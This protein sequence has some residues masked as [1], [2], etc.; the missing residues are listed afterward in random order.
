[1][2]LNKGNALSA[3]ERNQLA[4]QVHKYT[5]LST[6]YLLAANFRVSEN[7][8]VHELLK[9]R[10][11]TL[12]RLD[13]RFPGPTPDPLAKYTSYDPQSSSIGPA[14]V[15]AFQDYYHGEL[16]FGEGK[17]YRT[18]NYDIGG[19][20]KWT[21]R[22]AGNGDEQ[23]IVNS[24][25][26]LAQALVEDP[27]LKVLVMNG[28]YDLATP[29]SATEFVMQHLNVPQSLAS[30]IQMQYYEAG[31]MMYVHEPSMRKMKGDLDA[32]VSSTSRH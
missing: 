25:V 29:F 6:E 17:T 32:F 26:D 21:H 15:A 4:A 9:S 30:H 11:L 20:W 27:N 5:G 2:A 24:G 19:K 8:F 10:G 13:A 3:E 12:G 22:I 14:Y 1:V 23:P 28:Y 31:H 18:S 7:M 16:G